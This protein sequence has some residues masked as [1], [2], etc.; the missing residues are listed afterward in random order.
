MKSQ[1]VAKSSEGDLPPESFDVV[2]CA[3]LF[4]YLSQ[5]VCKRLAELF[6]GLLRPGGL[7]TFTN[8][9]SANPCQG[10][11]E[12]ILEWNLIYRDEDGMRDLLSTVAEVAEQPLASVTITA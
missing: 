7:L 11:M 3:G 10:A 12:Y 4:D 1:S 6:F 9:S 2:Y 8:V 5:R